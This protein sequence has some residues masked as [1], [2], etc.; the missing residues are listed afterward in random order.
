MPEQ[1]PLLEKARKPEE[2]AASDNPQSG[3]AHDL[4]AWVER[5]DEALKLKGG[6]AYF[7]RGLRFLLR[8]LVLLLR[9][10][11][12]LMRVVFAF[13]GVAFQWAAYQR[14]E[15]EIQ[16]DEQ[17]KPIFSGVRLAKCSAALVVG[18]CLFHVALSAVYFYS[19]RFE[20]LVYTTGKQELQAGELYQFTGCTSLPCSTD[21]NNGK[22]YRIEESWYF[23]YLVYP[24]Q[25]VFANIPQQDA[26]CLVKGYG[27]YFRRLKFLHRRLQ[28]YQK[29]YSVACRPYTDEEKQTAV[30]SGIVQPPEQRQTETPAVP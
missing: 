24:E 19:T 18:L 27:L 22:F 1:D 3:H 11:I 30:E 23:P 12:K 4:P 21:M 13:L 6:F 20:E 26:A 25:N 16:R 14:E 9:G 28:W 2:S 15:G 17:G 8:I 10:F 5:L 29:V 7:Y